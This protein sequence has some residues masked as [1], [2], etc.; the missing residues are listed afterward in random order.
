MQGVPRPVTGNTKEFATCRHPSMVLR[1]EFSGGVC[2]G[3]RQHAQLTMSGERSFA[4][5]HDYTASPGDSTVPV[6]V[7]ETWVGSW[8]V[9]GDALQFSGTVSG[10]HG[11]DGPFERSDGFSCSIEELFRSGVIVLH[12]GDARRK[13]SLKILECNW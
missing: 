9:L 12:Q 3:V 6:A 7:R 8:M 13:V 10:L 5:Q 2:G 1:A 4:L 11:R